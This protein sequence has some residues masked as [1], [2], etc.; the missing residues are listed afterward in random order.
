MSA[1]HRGRDL[2]SAQGHDL[3][4]TSTSEPKK[5]VTAV[6]DLKTVKKSV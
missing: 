6:A 5:E 1:G 2:L 4:V 3:S